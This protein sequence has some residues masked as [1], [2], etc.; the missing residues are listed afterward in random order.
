MI[1]IKKAN[2]HVSFTAPG[3]SFQTN[4]YKDI[5]QESL[6][7]KYLFLDMKLKL[8]TSY[9]SE[10]D[11][12]LKEIIKNVFDSI[13]NTIVIQLGDYHGILPYFLEN[14]TL[15]IKEC[16]LKNDNSMAMPY[17]VD[18][19][20]KETKPILK[21]KKLASFMGNIN[22]HALRKKLNI[23]IP[24]YYFENV[25][26]IWQFESHKQKSIRNK[27][28]VVCN[29]SQ[30][31]LCPLGKS[32]NTIRFFEAF[33]LGRIPV[34]ISDNTKLPFDWLIDYPKLIVQVPEK[35]IYCFMDYIQ[36]F[37]NKND[38]EYISSILKKSYETYLKWDIMQYIKLIIDRKIKI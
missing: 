20:I 8:H 12:I 27:Y 13:E 21:A 23:K 29:D 3:V 36:E 4:I 30:F 26:Y 33:K 7:Y 18:H 31:I 16:S 6:D 22:S 15:A 37:K 2:Y 1:K 17:N 14:N 28:N 25:E 11:L 24:H 35:D 34:L 38:L 19:E 5:L 9:S 10:H 32:V